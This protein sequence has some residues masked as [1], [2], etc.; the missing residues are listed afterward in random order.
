LKLDVS[1]K[2]A[3]I[4]KHQY[5]YQ[6]KST[7]QGLKPS[8]SSIYIGSDGIKTSVLNTEIINLMRLIHQ[9]SDTDYGHRK[10]TTA[11]KLYDYPLLVPCCF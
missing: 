7:K 11:L 1:L 2:I 9:D 10:M 8:L 3:K 4:S 5:Y 6:P